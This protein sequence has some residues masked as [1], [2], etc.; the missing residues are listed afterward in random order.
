MTLGGVG[1][2]DTRR[3]VPSSGLMEQINTSMMATK[4]AFFSIQE[5]IA[6]CVGLIL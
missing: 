2:F 3:L 1:L 6:V 4:L 5:H